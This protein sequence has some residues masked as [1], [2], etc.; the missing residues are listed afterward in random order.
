MLN[1]PIPDQERSGISMIRAQSD[2]ASDGDLS[3]SALLLAFWERKFLVAL[4]VVASVVAGYY[5]A[6]SRTE[7]YTARADVMLNLAQQGGEDVGVLASGISGDWREIATQLQLIISRNLIGEV[8]DTLEL[9]ENPAY[10]PWLA[11]SEPEQSLLPEWLSPKEWVGGLLPEGLPFTGWL[12]DGDAAEPPPATPAEKVR[13]H[14]IRTLINQT[15]VQQSGDSLI[16]WITVTTPDPELSARL[17]T[18]IADQ[19]IV[20]QIALKYEATEKAATWLTNRVGELRE[21]VEAADSTVARFRAENELIN[22]ERLLVLGQRVLSLRQTRQEVVERQ[23]SAQQRVDAIEALLPAESY[24][25][26]ARIADVPALED[27]AGN[28]VAASTEEART[29]ARDAFRA[30]LD[31]VLDRLRREATR[32]AESI[33]RLNELIAEAE[34]RQSKEAA[35]RV[36][37]A[38]LERE[39]EAARSIYETFLSREKET[40]IQQGAQK[41]DSVVIAEAWVPSGPSHPNTTRIVLISLLVGVALSGGVVIG[42]EALR[43]TFS[44][45]EELERY[46]GRRILGL[47]PMFRPP[48]GT[49]VLDYVT[50]RPNTPFVEAV[51]NLRT[52]IRFVSIDSPA[53]VVAVVSSVEAEGKSTLSLAL[54]QVTGTQPNSRV[55][56]IDGDLRR[57]RASSLLGGRKGP[58]ITAYIG[59]KAELD[60]II[61]RPDRASFDMIYADRSPRITADI[62]A[63]RRFAEMIE[64][65]RRR[66]DMIVIDTPPVLALSDARI[67]ISHADLALFTVSW[68]GTRRRPLRAAL[69]SLELSGADKIALV[70]NRTNIRKSVGYYGTAY[71]GTK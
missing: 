19:Y 9:T 21:A 7:L 17:A 62:F 8:V 54:A 28:I 22:D 29:V 66:Y 34:A 30:E 35:A 51:R 15:Q 41:A 61:V 43:Q 12:R 56:V 48:W 5:Y 40:S 50:T 69:N 44:E 47:I 18:A 53:K 14:A 38:Q 23:S 58:G 4:I 39:A 67:I 57:R 6:K 20:R 3:A 52:S 37:L 31:G 11:R 24:A 65:L 13:Q 45:P 36:Q 42:L 16:F 71:Y 64:E 49:S 26:I 10:N 1:T 68:K 46:T 27:L 55:L 63:S 2:A 32:S 25:E 60:D 70:F 59:E 33:E